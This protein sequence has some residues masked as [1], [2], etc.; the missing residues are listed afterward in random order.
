MNTKETILSLVKQV[1][2]EAVTV[3]GLKDP[4]HV[5][6]LTGKERDSFESACFVQKGK[7]RQL[8]T[9][10]IRSKLLV[11]AICTAKGERIFI[12]TD[13]EALGNI[14]ADVLDKLFTVA[15]KLSGLAQDDIEE[16]AGN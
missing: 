14:P 1:T 11:R 13:I 10:N 15:Q 7:N 5:K 12:D 4:I 3:K 8:N 9:E 2:I 6:S 16:I